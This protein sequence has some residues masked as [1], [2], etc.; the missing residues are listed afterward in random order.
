[1]PAYAQPLDDI[2][3]SRAKVRVCRILLTTSEALSAREIGR[4]TGTAKRSVDLALVDLLQLGLVVRQGSSSVSPYRINRRHV[5]VEHALAPLFLG[6]DETMQEMFAALRK[7]VIAEAV[8]AK[9]GLAWAGVFGSMARGDHT[10]ESD[11]DLAVIVDDRTATSRVHDAL[12]DQAPSFTSRFGRRLSP[13]VMSSSQFGR[14]LKD[15]DSLALTMVRDGRR[16]A[17]TV[18]ELEHLA[19][20]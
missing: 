17:G 7:M 13:L 10:I 20:G 15:R 9:S 8:L 19:D 1:M 11:L 6:E 5:L 16:L 18:H 4:R 14:M 12:S 2:L 3:G